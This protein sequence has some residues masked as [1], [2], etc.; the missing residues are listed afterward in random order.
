MS[1]ER[2]DHRLELE[3][4]APRLL[5]IFDKNKEPGDNY[6]VSIDNNTVIIYNNGINCITVDEP[7][8]ID[9]K[10]VL[11]IGYVKKC[12]EQKSGTTNVRNFIR[13]GLKY[14]YDTIDLVNIAGIPITINDRKPEE[15]SAATIKIDLTKFK[16]LTTGNSWYSQFGFEYRTT[17]DKQMKLQEF[18]NSPFSFLID[19]FNVYLDEYVALG[20]ITEFKSFEIKTNFLHDIKGYIFLFNEYF[21]LGIDGDLGLNLQIAETFNLLL[22]RIMAI[23]T[24]IN[25]SESSLKE[26]TDF[27]AQVVRFTSFMDY[28]LSTIIRICFKEPLTKSSNKIL[29]DFISNYRLLFLDLKTIPFNPETSGGKSTKRKYTKQKSTKRKY[30]K[31]K[32]SKRKY[33]KQKS[34]KYQ[35]K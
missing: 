18:I 32:S 16:L 22:R 3:F 13:F 23:Y 33:T 26:K 10:Y 5:E 15:V 27:R 1:I 2:K 25:N 14:G 29:T 6:T 20:L 19:K 34:K 11:T 31:Q 28:I 8:N 12:N 17:I 21:H 7:T 24:I 30:T 9:G 35:R 4:V